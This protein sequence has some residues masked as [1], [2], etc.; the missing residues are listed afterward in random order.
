MPDS[1]A[2]LSRRSL[3][4]NTLNT[5]AL[6]AI[7]PALARASRAGSNPV[8]ESFPLGSIRLL[9]SVY[10]SA[11][12]ANR[13]YLH[14]LEPDR[15]LHNFRAQ[16]GLKPKGALYGG[17]ESDS[18]AGHT[19]GHY[20]S[21]CSLMHAQTG[22]ME[23]KRRVGYIVAE[24]A[25]CQARASDGYVG[26]FTRKRG[27]AME[28][29][30]FAM[31]EVR[32]GEIRSTGFDLNGSWSPFYNWHKLLAGLLDAD[33]HCNLRQAVRIAERLGGYIE[34]VFAALTD[35][36]IQSV[37]SCEYGGLN[38]SFAELYARTG[39]QRWLRL[40]RSIYD[41]KVLDP[42]THRV[43]SLANVHANTQIPKV[44]GLARLYELT[45]D[46]RYAEAS[47]FFWETVTAQYTYVIGGN[48]D[49]EY[50]QTPCSIS[51]HI[52]EQT[53][54]SCNSYNMLKLTR[55]LYA[56]LPDARYFDYYERTHLNNILA[57]QNPRTGMFA[58]MNP[59]MS[60]S[61]REFSSPFEDFW[62][63]VG[64]GMESHSKHG[65]SIYWRRGSEL[66]VN[67]YIP[68]T[69]HWAAEGTRLE[70]TTDYPFAETIRI[71][72]LERQSEAPATL[73][74][75]IPGWCGGPG[76]TLNGNPLPC[77]PK[78][79]YVR[80]SRVWKSG[81]VVELRLPA[82]LRTESTV[83]D[84]QTV[85]L[86]YGPLV[87]AADL[88]PAA[89][90]WKGLPPVLV[91]SDVLSGITPTGSTPASFRTKG[92]V[93]P[94]DVTLSPF[95]LQHERNTAVYF[96]HFT[97]SQ[98]QVEQAR[99]R[100]E[101]QYLADLQARSADV[102]HLGEM[103]AERDHALEAKLSYPVVYRGRNGRDA[104]AGGYFEFT[105]KT[106]PGPLVLQA[107]YW[108]EERN[109]RFRIL[110]GGELVATE[111]LEANKPGEFFEQDYPIPVS[112]T[113]GKPTVRVRFEPEERVSAGPV[114][115]VRL[116]SGN[117]E[118]PAA[119]T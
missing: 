103:Q 106:R 17:W 43:D 64:T 97:E 22:D 94:D 35:S 67:L 11:L 24:L 109:R 57:Q 23:C 102:M 66:I 84:A 86:L 44:I 71:R 14:T 41:R 40:A 48:G 75:R 32:R 27:D 65:E 58:Y 3:L 108:G 8:A 46:Q 82:T 78:S 9:P 12:E 38:D 47:A 34:G 7:A 119:A 105:F 31:E 83:D 30:R 113:D 99:Y 100:A 77:T 39:D 29:G 73:T 19:L 92:L 21:A 98:W 1:L 112:L 79:G 93:R 117:P 68:S 2:S 110:V 76:L 15:L 42:L 54:E 107:T 87:L 62:C 50:F 16:A 10:S 45:G 36:Q 89:Q 25:L 37:L 4:R 101:Q 56:R 116:F 91:G 72:V 104:R 70:M 53:C 95:A 118:T 59:L 69:L 5:A 60:G 13:S 115:G 52:T 55:H 49:R 26:G 88:G 51:K 111:R 33:R 96:K 61:H 81:D 80:T 85:A 18:I 6:L 20:L 74:L 90:T 114:F 63:C 28:N